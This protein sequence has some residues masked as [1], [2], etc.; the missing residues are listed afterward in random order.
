ML[1]GAVPAGEVQLIDARAFAGWGHDYDRFRLLSI[2]KD[3][4]LAACSHT[5]EV[6]LLACLMRNFGVFFPIRAKLINP[7]RIKLQNNKTLGLTKTADEIKNG[8]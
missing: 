3:S 4:E 2:E 1:P 7:I 6:Q 5:K 8:Q